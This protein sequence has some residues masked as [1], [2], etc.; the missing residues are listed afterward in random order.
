MASL[1]FAKVLGLAACISVL[2]PAMPVTQDAP[3]ASFRLAKDSEYVY[4]TVKVE[5]SDIQGLAKGLSPQSLPAIYKDDS[6]TLSLLPDGGKPVTI[7]YSP[8]GGFGYT[9]DGIPAANFK[10][11]YGLGIDGTVGDSTDKDKSWQVEA[12]IPWDAI[13]CAPNTP[14]RGFLQIR[15]K[16]SADVATFPSGVDT[17]TPAAWPSLTTAPYLFANKATSPLID[18]RTDTTEWPE[19]E[20]LVSLPAWQT[21]QATAVITMQPGVAPTLDESRNPAGLKPVGAL[22]FASTNADLLKPSSPTRGVIA[23]DGSIGFTD[24]PFLGMG[25]WYS[26]DRVDHHR[27]ELLGMQR[28]GI[29]VAYCVTGGTGVA[30]VLDMK[31]Q[32]VLVAAKQELALRGEA[33]PA[34]APYIAIQSDDA[35]LD[36]TTPA[37]LDRLWDSIQKWVLSTPPQ[38][39]HLVP[40]GA[41]TPTGTVMAVP[42]I[43]DGESVILPSDAAW[44]NTLRQRFAERFGSAAG[45]PTLVFVGGEKLT[46]NSS[47]LYGSIGRTLRPASPS[48]AVVSP[49]GQK[50]FVPRKLGET[51]R[52]S[53]D[54]SRS[55]D[56]VLINSWNDFASGNE[57][58]PSRQYGE[59]YVGLTRLYKTNGASG[60][61]VDVRVQTTGIPTVVASPEL[62]VADVTIQNKG[63]APLEPSAVKVGYRWLQNDKVIAAIPTS[64]R[65]TALLAGGTSV[66]AKVGVLCS[67][68]GATPLP[69]GDYVLEFVTETANTTRTTSQVVTVK[70]KVPFAEIRST[71]LSP[72]QRTGA[73]VP[74]TAD[75]RF[76]GSNGI[77]PGTYKLFWRI[78]SADKTVVLSTGETQQAKALRPGAW[79][80]LR[81]VVDFRDAERQLLAGAYP[82]QTGTAEGA[83]LP[84]HVW[85]QFLVKDSEGNVITEP[86]EQAA[87][88]YPGN[89]EARVRLVT[90]LGQTTF[91]AGSDGQVTV[92]IANT[93]VEKWTKGSVGLTGRWF[94]ADGFPMSVNLALP[95]EYIKTD[96]PVGESSDLQVTFRVPDRPGR[97]I[98]AVLP[99]RPPDFFL[100]T[101]PVTRSEDAV[102]VGVTVTGG[103]AVML[104]LQDKF[105]TDAVAYENAPRDGDVDGLGA[106]FP[107]EWFPTDRYGINAGQLFYPSG[108]ASDISSEIVRSTSFK[109]GPT[110]PGAKNA[111]SGKGQKIDVPA[112]KYVALHI[113]AVIIGNQ[114]KPVQLTLR[115][116]DGKSEVVTRNVRDWASPVRA[117]EAISMRFP[118]KRMPTGD[119]DA[120]LAWQHLVI[121]VRPAADLI[122]IDLPKDASLKIFAISLER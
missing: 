76:A 94:Q 27:R 18:G 58:A 101:H 48:I 42:V 78:L 40:V 70:S 97:Y 77:T 64:S 74:V 80:Q 120:L 62:F 9:K 17:A 113:A 68:D 65:L 43:I 3:K 122:G 41:A 30:G 102:F 108:Y 121:P 59:G 5:T 55:A 29:D 47:G 87:A 57:I 24:Q 12:A 15:K 119:Q 85:V 20:V 36:A 79:E 67:I 53:W 28:A 60:T 86:F 75:V 82:E 16:G 90:P 4:L 45:S 10:L 109:F 117:D 99:M 106:T 54:A 2:S 92:N 100:T 81:A 111:V 33:T 51:Y 38:M 114:A 69:D 31:A 107:G 34:L 118:R 21:K 93:G 39:R 26:S 1:R 104:D 13:G 63:T 110:T 84:S 88:V 73:R 112:N 72:L 49:G 44:A 61:L 11:K 115:Y 6:V 56:W 95:T 25:P 116:K 7:T 91:N 105:D 32:L 22:Y 98:L 89:E 23:R 83:T 37:G 35:P 103:R 14:L 46:S 71:S 8:A 50:P 52:Q 66:T 96:I 19:S